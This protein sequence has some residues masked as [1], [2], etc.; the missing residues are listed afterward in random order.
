MAFN[1]LTIRTGESDDGALYPVLGAQRDEVE[2]EALDGPSVTK[3]YADAAHIFRVIGSSLHEEAHVRDVRLTVYVTDARV[4]VACSKYD[5]GGGWR[6]GL[7]AVPLNAI[8]IAR[9]AHRRQGKMLVGHVRYP[10]LG[11]VSFSEKTSWSSTD[12]LRL[13]DTERVDGNDRDMLLELRFP[14]GTDVAWLAHAICQRAATYRL[15][16][17]SDLTET[18]VAQFEAL[19]ASGPR[20]G[21]PKEFTVYSMPTRYFVTASSAYPKGGAQQRRDGASP[22]VSSSQGAPP[23]QVAA[24]TPAMPPPQAR[25]SATDVSPLGL[26]SAPLSAQPPPRPSATE[27][28]V[29][30]SPAQWAQDPFGRHE[31]R[32]WTGALWSEH[33]SDGGQASIDVWPR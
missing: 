25:P 18:E 27:P 28:I 16:N 20:P 10:W 4:A 17:D 1:I 15:N 8:S 11:S 6:G 22:P 2:L 33:V 23:T 12:T 29:A 5:K 9:A 21:T 7:L 13:R 26:V 31:L 32:Y 3:L 30:V 19:R 24:P 14:K